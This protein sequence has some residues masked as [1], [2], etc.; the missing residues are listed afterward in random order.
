MAIQPP[1]FP[2][3]PFNA[4]SVN[5]TPDIPG[6]NGDCQH[7]G[8][9]VF[10]DHLIN[11]PERTALHGMSGNK[12]FIDFLSV[13][14]PVGFGETERGHT[15]ERN[16]VKLGIAGSGKQEQLICSPCGYTAQWPWSWRELPERVP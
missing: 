14:K 8:G 16:T 11:Y 9:F 15:A 2:G 7:H 6:G 13:M 1:R 3:L 4:V 12:K 10:G 5:S